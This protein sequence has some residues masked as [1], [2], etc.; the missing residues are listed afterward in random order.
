MSKF[1][2]DDDESEMI[3][4]EDS[5]PEYAIYDGRIRLCSSCFIIFSMKHIFGSF[6]TEKVLLTK[7]RDAHNAQSVT[8]NISPQR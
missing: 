5:M 1:L 4:R 8:P 7:S 2:H 3:R 6:T